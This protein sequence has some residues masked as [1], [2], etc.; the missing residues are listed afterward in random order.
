MTINTAGGRTAH[1]RMRFRWRIAC[2]LLLATVLPGCTVIEVSIRDGNAANAIH[3]EGAIYGTRY[4][5]AA[6]DPGRPS[7]SGIHDVIIE[8]NFFYD[9]IGVVTLGFYK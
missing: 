3:S 6:P 8:D 2:G 9:I 4:I 5:V 1:S 7:N